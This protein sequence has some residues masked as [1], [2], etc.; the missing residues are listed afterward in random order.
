MSEIKDL[1]ILLNDYYST[2]RDE[3]LIIDNILC[4]GVVL[5]IDEVETEPTLFGSIEG[6]VKPFST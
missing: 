2:R 6:K 4:Q 1:R 5:K 3:C